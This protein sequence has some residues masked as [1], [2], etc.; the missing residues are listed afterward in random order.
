MQG[1]EV[2]CVVELAEASLLPDLQPSITKG[3]TLNKAKSIKQKLVNCQNVPSLTFKHSDQ[4]R[5]LSISFNN[6]VH[7]ETFRMGQLR[8]C[9]NKQIEPM[10]HRQGAQVEDKIT[11]P[12]LTVHLFHT[13][14][15][16]I[17]ARA[18]HIY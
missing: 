3:Y 6:T 10:K 5:Y 11:A 7:Y 18:Y 13:Q 9:Q 14:K 16:I 15:Q 12:L 1:Q 17:A 8:Y 2:G 4:E